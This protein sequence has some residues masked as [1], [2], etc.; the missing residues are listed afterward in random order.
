M[1]AIILAA[2]KGERLY[3]LTRN[4]PKSL[5]EIGNGIS[6]LENQIMSLSS[7]GIRDIVI[8]VGYKAEQIEA[9][10]K[11]LKE[12]NC[13]VK[14][15]YNPFFDIS[16]NLISIFFALPDM[17]DDFLIINGDD[18]FVPSVIQRLL[19]E[20]KDKEICMVIDKKGKYDEDDMKVVIEKDK[21]KKIGKTIE[22]AEANGESI[23]IMRVTGR[24]REFFK[25]VMCDLVRDEKNRG[26]FYLAIFQQLINI[27]WTV[28]YL[29]VD[30]DDWAE[31]D[32]H[33]D[34]E[35]VR[36]YTKVFTKSWS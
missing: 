31:V 13:N 25:K 8:V 4:T 23:G 29:E 32:F 11:T 14:T 20:D 2:G 36:T 21:V 18:V 22:I 28:N 9:K 16:N 30:E 33:P 12:I 10:V 15:I 24:S 6:L 5:L 35:L 17:N 19:N 27:G 1:K 3:P 26:V 7:A 34:L